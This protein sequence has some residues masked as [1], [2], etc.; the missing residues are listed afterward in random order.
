MEQLRELDISDND[1]LTEQGSI[2]WARAIDARGLP[3]LESFDMTQMR[4][5]TA[6]GLSAIAHA[7]IKG[8]PKL[9]EIHLRGSG[10]ENGGHHDAIR[11]MLEAAGRSGEVAVS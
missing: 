3:M 1:A 6:V 5:M 8:C 7:F 4:E 10:P 11:G 2:T 9:K